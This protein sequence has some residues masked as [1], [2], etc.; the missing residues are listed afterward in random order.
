MNKDMFLSC[1]QRVLFTGNY[2]CFME[3]SKLVVKI[4]FNVKKICN[5]THPNYFYIISTYR[6]YL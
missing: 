1:V 2:F 3:Q 6:S 4:N 5:V